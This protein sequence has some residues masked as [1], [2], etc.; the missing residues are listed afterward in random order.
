MEWALL[1]TVLTHS[2]LLRYPSFQ[3]I[4][5]PFAHTM[6]MR[7]YLDPLLSHIIVIP[8]CFWPGSSDLRRWMPASAGMTGI[9]DVCLNFVDLILAPVK[10]KSIGNSPA[11][12]HWNRRLNCTNVSFKWDSNG[13]V[14]LF[15]LYA[16][17]GR[18]NQYTVRG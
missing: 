7:Y 18:T 13:V 17:L 12:K 6:T 9:F 11:F 1:I 15:H 5:T 2:S 14:Y 8:A 10:F 3:Y 16:V 4:T